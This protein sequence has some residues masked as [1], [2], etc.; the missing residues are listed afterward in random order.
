MDIEKVQ[1]KNTPLLTVIVA[2]LNQAKYLSD[3]INE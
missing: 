3:F 2:S 1:P